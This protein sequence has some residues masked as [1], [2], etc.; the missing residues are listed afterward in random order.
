M[1][2][3][4]VKLKTMPTSP[5]VDLESLKSRI[6]EVIVANDGE[7]IEQIEEPIAF[8]L[9]AIITKFKW[10]QEKESDVAADAVSKLEDVNSCQVT[11]VSLMFA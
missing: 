1:G 8:G 7:I 6:E 9:K 4:S 11:E 10:D 3:A 5:D 2:N